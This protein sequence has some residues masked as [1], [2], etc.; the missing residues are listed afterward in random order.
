[1]QSASHHKDKIFPDRKQDCRGDFRLFNDIVSV[2]ERDNLFF[3]PSTIVQGTTCV[4]VLTTV[5]YYIL[6]HLHKFSQIPE[7]FVDNFVTDPRN[8][9][10]QTYNQPQQSK[11]AAKQL[12]QSS[13]NEYS[14]RL[15]EISLMP[16]FQLERFFNF[17]QSISDLARSLDNYSVFLNTK[18]TTTQQ[19][20]SRETVSGKS[21]LICGKVNFL[22]PHSLI[23]RYRELENTLLVK[24]DYE[25]V[26]IDEF[27]PYDI[28]LKS[29]YISDLSLPI[30]FE[31][32]SCTQGNQKIWFIWKVPNTAANRDTS[33]SVALC[34]TIE[35]KH[36]KMYHSRAMKRKFTNH[37]GRIFENPK[38]CNIG[39]VMKEVYED[40][41]G[42]CSVNQTKIT[43][44]VKNR[45]KLYLDCENP[46]M[47]VDLRELNSGQIR[48]YDPFFE[49][50]DSYIN[51]TTL[52]A[53]HER[54]HEAIGRLAVAISVRD[55][56]NQVSK[57]LDPNIPIPSESYLRLQFWPKNRHFHSSVHYTGRFNLRYRIQTR[58]LRGEHED[59]HYSNMVF[60]H[61]REFLIKFRDFSSFISIDDKCHI[62][63]G[64]P[65]LPVTCA[66]RGRP[67]IVEGD[68]ETFSAS[69]HD[70]TKFKLIPSA[71]LLIDIPTDI[72]GSFYNGTLFV[73][74]KD[75]I[76]QTSTPFR[77]ATELI[78]LLQ[79]TGNVNPILGIY[80]DGGPD[81]RITYLSVQ[82]SLIA[83]FITLN[84][85]MLVAARTAP[86]QSFRNP[87]E[88]CMA[89][90]N[91]GLQ[92][93]SICR[94]KMDE[95]GEKQILKA[96]SLKSLRKVAE[97]SSVIKE[98]MQKSVQAP[99]QLLNSVFQRLSYNSQPVQVTKSATEESIN[100]TI[101]TVTDLDPN[102][103]IRKLQKC[104]LKNYPN[105][106]K[107]MDTHCTLRHYFLCI[108]KCK[109]I[110][111]CDYCS[112][113][114]PQIPNF[115]KLDPLPDPVPDV[116]MT[117]YKPFESVWGTCTSE[118]HRPSM[119][120]NSGTGISKKTKSRKRKLPTTTHTSADAEKVQ[121]D[122]QPIDCRKSAETVRSFVSCYMCGKP[123]CLYSSRKLTDE[124]QV[125]L[126]KTTEDILY[127]CGSPPFVNFL[128][129]EDE[130]S[131]DDDVCIHY[132]SKRRNFPPCCYVCGD[133]LELWEG[134]GHPVCESCTNLKRFRT[135]G[136]KTR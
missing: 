35:E 75:Q 123:R 115:E 50:L 1:M 17:R 20:H 128:L 30:T 91:L 29:K 13:I 69:D 105:L 90:L 95:E 98:K 72:G 11:H 53:A 87:V 70:F 37:Y 112:K 55:L 10:S 15:F 133:S 103:D 66:Q 107:F 23:Q 134:D 117:H 116:D 86:L 99:I 82:A 5:L 85:D 79:T 109:N 31:I 73:G 3:T 14:N 18:T 135:R 59:A 101:K 106:V 45:L 7:Y 44:E 63:V 8:L 61:L 24:P 122:P 47:A 64:E 102:V 41:T 49:A 67:N 80:S 124:Q 26:C 84:L 32:L 129:C 108:K 127:S 22:R 89:T 83:L 130:V 42:D 92:A 46:D 132:Y 6:P 12:T 54:R 57:D 38:K 81:H 27:A 33:R 25:P 93:V 100:K 77:H 9:F 136:A 52:N 121:D 110:V 2:M 71:V 120:E 48:K 51:R 118:T 58:Q 104:H 96:N 65:G 68:G 97:Q 126:E 19:Q 43:S 74:V 4:N 88:R 28:K 119:K 114:P 40:L 94:E 16:V 131:C 78:N 34:K 62:K 111:N 125:K 113:N 76:F 39:T 56:I 21:T 36:L 60:R